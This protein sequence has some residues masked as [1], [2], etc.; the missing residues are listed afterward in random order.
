MYESFLRNGLPQSR[1]SPTFLEP[2][3]QGCTPVPYLEP[4]LNSISLY[5]PRSPKCYVPLNC[6]ERSGV[7]VFHPPRWPISSF[8]ILSIQFK[9][10]NGR[11]WEEKSRFNEGNAR[12]RSSQRK[13]NTHREFSKLF[14][15]TCVQVSEV[16]TAL[17]PLPSDLFLSGLCT[18]NFKHFLSRCTARHSLS[19]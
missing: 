8:F 13:S 12:N 3:S 6:F 18:N 10:L 1:N 9:I 16:S 4:L 15:L 7:F 14:Q 11:L 17:P 2:C 5:S 19:G